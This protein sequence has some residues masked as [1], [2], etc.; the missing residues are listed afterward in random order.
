MSVSIPDALLNPGVEES[1]FS[2]GHSLKCSVFLSRYLPKT[3]AQFRD[4]PH[5]STVAVCPEFFFNLGHL[6]NCLLECNTRYYPN[7]YVH[8]GASLRTYYHG[9]FE[10]LHIAEGVFIEGR[11]CEVFSSMMLSSW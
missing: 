10:F 4:Y 2:H 7:Y 9:P 5:R 3:L 8:T 1:C 11:T 6:F